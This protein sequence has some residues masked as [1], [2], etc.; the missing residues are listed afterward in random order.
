MSRLASALLLA[1]ILT[2]V[3]VATALAAPGDP[4]ATFGTDGRVT[5]DFGGKTGAFRDAALQPDGKIVLVGYVFQPAT[6]GRHTDM[7]VVRLNAD[8]STDQEFGT[9]GMRQIGTT[10]GPTPGPDVANAVALQPDGKIVVGGYSY[11]G[12]VRES[13][14]VRLTPSGSLDASFSPGG[15]RA[16]ASPAC[17]SGR[18]TTSP[19][20]RQARSSRP[21]PGCG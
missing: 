14:V 15:T 16:L 5:V 6:T 2:L 4:D 19:S 17:A 18:P 8:G 20:T 7:I 11:A 1:L 10:N 3:I 12:S 13:T 21:G 9:A